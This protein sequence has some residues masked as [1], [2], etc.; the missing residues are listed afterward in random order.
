MPI[1]LVIKS[2]SINRTL[3]VW[4]PL[5][6]QLSSTILCSLVSYTTPLIKYLYVASNEHASNAFVPKCLSN[7]SKSAAKQEMHCYCYSCV[8]LAFIMF[9]LIYKECANCKN[10]LCSIIQSLHVLLTPGCVKS[11]PTY[12]ENW[13]SVYLC[14]RF[15]HQYRH[16]ISMW[17]MQS[18]ALY[19][20]RI[21][22]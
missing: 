10:L 14:F 22:A 8:R 1:T 11:L 19:S 13:K 5:F 6:T 15:V 12:K 2:N 7:Q 21:E 16:A 20:G 9:M 18:R 3:L 17:R 4:S